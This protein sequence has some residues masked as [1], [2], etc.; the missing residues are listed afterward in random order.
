MVGFR[1]ADSGLGKVISKLKGCV[2]L[3][4]FCDIPSE[5]RFDGEP[6]ALFELPYFVEVILKT[7]SK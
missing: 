3:Q 7:V 2:V 1:I 6:F 4:P 5:R